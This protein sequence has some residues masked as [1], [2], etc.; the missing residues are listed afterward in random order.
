MRRIKVPL[1]GMELGHV[2]VY[3]VECGDG[4]GLIDVGIATY[5]AA[6]GLL[7]GLREAGIRPWDVTHIFLTHFH[8]DHSTLLSLLSQI[9][10]AEYYIG[11]AELNV[12]SDFDGFLNELFSEYIRQGAPSGFVEEAKRVAPMVRFKKAFEDIWRLDWRKVRDGEDLPC[13]LKAVWTPGHTPGHTVYVEGRRVYTGDHI[14]PKI[15][16]NISYWY[17]I[18]GYDPLGEYMRS[19]LKTKGLGVGYPAHGEVIEDLDSRIDEI[20]K[21]HEERLAEV[22]SALRGGPLTAYEVARRIRWD[23]GPFDGLD[24]YNKFF[25]VGEALAH[26]VHLESVGRVESFERDGVVYWRAAKA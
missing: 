7:K 26:L 9:A 17:K 15:T 5:D 2:N 1:P 22:E 12:G 19:L 8:A 6:V 4:Y 16:P 14:L 18:E 13:G 21:H 23:I 3:V 25:A 20:L 24:V 10:P 11:E